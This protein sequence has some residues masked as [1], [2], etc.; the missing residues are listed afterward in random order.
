MLPL[1]VVLSILDYTLIV[2]YN[3]A[4]AQIF[5]GP[6]SSAMGGTGR[7]GIDMTE[8]GTLNPAM[9]GFAKRLEFETFYQ[10]GRLEPEKN[11][12]QYG[13]SV[14]DSGA[15]SLFPGSFTY[16]HMYSKYPSQNHT[17]T[18]LLH[19]AMGEFINKKFSAGVSVYRAESTFD[20]SKQKV[21][22]WNGQAG[23]LYLITPD[24]GLAYVMDNVFRKNDIHDEEKFLAQA[25]SIG[26]YYRYSSVGRFRADAVYSDQKNLPAKWNWHLGYDS[27][28]SEFFTLRLGTF[29]KNAEDQRGWSAGFSFDGPNLKVGYSYQRQE[30]NGGGALHG[31]DFRLAF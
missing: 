27:P 11:H 22:R 19:L 1:F 17:S 9:L 18:E 30:E 4:E 21:T 31:V 6:I 2:T 5:A 3:R 20:I 29:W 10:Q 7:A 14:V 28:L 15:D 25:H 16:A 26:T 24:L 8:A 13:A 12:T 23:V